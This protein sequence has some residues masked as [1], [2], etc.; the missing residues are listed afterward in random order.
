L[1]ALDSLSLTGLT[2]TR[3]A[4]LSLILAAS[5]AAALSVGKGCC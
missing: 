2:L 4:G 3:L 5:A 1:S